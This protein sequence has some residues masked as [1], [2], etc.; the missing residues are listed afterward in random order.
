MGVYVFRSPHFGFA[1]A[2]PAWAP[3]AAAFYRRNRA[4]F[5]PFDPVQPED[6][7]TTEGQR[8]MLAQAEALAQADRGFRFL[9]VQPRHPGKVVGVTA[10][11]E[12]V[13]GAFQSCFLSYKLDRTLWGRGLGSEAIASTTEWA[14]RVLK[15]HRAEANIMPRN[16]PSLG[17]AARAGFLREGVSPQY[18]CINGVWEDHVHM[19]RLNP[20]TTP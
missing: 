18:L 3:S 4:A 9:L 6:F 5:A 11:N 2:S 15:L 12:I 14:F 17:A 13:G 7:F 19:V 8:D 16:A 20:Q 1:A 10:L